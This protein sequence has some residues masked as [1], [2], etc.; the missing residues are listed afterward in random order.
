MFWFKKIVAR[1]FYPF[2]L[3]LLLLLLGTLLLWR[4]KQQ[5]M[6]KL[7]V[8]VGTILLVFF[9][10]G[11]PSSVLLKP[12][13]SKYPPVHS[14][15]D[16]HIKWIVVLSGKVVSDP[17]VPIT[18]QVAEPSLARLIE[19]I[20]IH[21]ELPGSK[22]MLTGGSYTGQIPASEVMARLAQ[23]LGVSRN[24]LVLEVESRD[25]KDQ[26]LLVQ[27][28]VKE[29][30]FILVTSASHMVR[31]IALFKKLGMSPIPAPTNHLVMKSQDK[32]FR[33]PLPSSYNLYKA[34]VAIH[35]YL[36]LIWAKLRGQI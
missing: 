20:R 13:E 8:T 10:Y 36:G 1:F 23:I 18:S 21:K 22:L 19:A 32:R 31:S 35:E 33:V 25:T 9:S 7:F 4:K 34:R 5:R 24:D 29:D 11:F 17:E 12:L 27:E 6:G 15:E 2:P 16:K 26:A 28:I 14:V 30:K 3:C